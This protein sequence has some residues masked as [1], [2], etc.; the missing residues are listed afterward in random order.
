MTLRRT[1]A[2][3]VLLALLSSAA[4]TAQ[5]DR[6][7]DAVEFVEIDAVVLDGKGRPLHGLS[8]S[9]FSV[10]EGG[11]PVAIGTVSEVR[12]PVPNDPDSARTIVVLLDDSGVASLG[13]ETIQVIA[14][15][16]VA[17]ALPGDEVSV[18]R[19]HGRDDEPYGDRFTSE[20]RIRAYRGSSWPFDYWSV[21]ETVLARVRD[22]SRQIAANAARRKVVICIGSSPI[23]N[24]SQPRGSTPP[25]FD[26]T[27][28]DAV[29]SAATANVA[30]YALIPG[31]TGYRLDGLAEVTGG[32]VFPTGSNVAVPIDRILQDAANHYVIGYFGSASSGERLRRVE[33]KTTVK[34]ARL[35][36][37]RLR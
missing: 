7:T 36:A 23:C 37:R 11:K 9:D 30:Y 4:L 14:R 35:H 22:I 5:R 32:E 12:G 20:E 21:T 25:S 34:G 33:V 19:L 29:A 16:V 26:T 27:W 2:V 17:S 3:I 6:A 8:R 31:R 24:I 28:R 13:T 18:V 15:G 1:P 10:K